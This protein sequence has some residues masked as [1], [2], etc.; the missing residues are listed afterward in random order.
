MID[1]STLKNALYGKFKKLT[2]TDSYVTIRGKCEAL[3][4]NVTGVYECNEIMVRAKSASNDIVVWGENLK[5]N[6]YV[7]NCVSVSG[8]ISSV[9][10]NNNGVKL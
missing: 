2:F 9:E 6:D 8:T 1:F 10:I 7:D 4:E 3:I 5:I